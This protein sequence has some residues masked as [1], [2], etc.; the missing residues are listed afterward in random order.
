MNTNYFNDKLNVY[1]N[2][3]NRYVERRY[4]LNAQLPSVTHVTNS[5]TLPICN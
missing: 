3:I 5:I 4:I 1:G 2:Y